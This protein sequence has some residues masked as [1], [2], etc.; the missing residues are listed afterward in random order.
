MMLPGFLLVLPDAL[1][2]TA[3][4]GQIQPM[5]AAAKSPQILVA[6]YLAAEEANEVRHEYLGGSVYAMAGET[7]AH[8]TIALILATAIRQR[9]KS[10]CKLYMGAVRVNFQLR[11]DEYYYYPDIVVTC[12]PSDNDPRFVRSPRL[13][14]EVLSESTERVDRREKFFA[15]TTI[16]SLEEYILIAQDLPEATRFRRENGWRLEKTAGVNAS[17]AFRSLQLDLPLAG[18]YEGI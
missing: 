17:L 11:G 2:R 18:A 15:Y 7:R 1:A 5:H 8:N 13:I 3:L 14:I 6:D 16:D 9:L 10:P 4:F 12:N